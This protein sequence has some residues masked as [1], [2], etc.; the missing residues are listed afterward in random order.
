VQNNRDDLEFFNDFGG[1]AGD[2]REYVLLLNGDNR[3]PAPWINVIANPKFGFSI[4]ETGA[5][6]TW[7]YN[8]RE[9][10]ITPWSNDPVCDHASEAIYIRDN[11]TGNMMTPMSLGRVDR[12]GYRVRHGFGYSV[13]YHEEGGL[14]QELRVFTPKE[15]LIKIWELDLDNVSG[16]ELSLSLTYYVE[17]VLGIERNQTNPY[18]VTSF[19]NRQEYL[20]A[21]NVYNQVYRQYQGFIFSSDHVVGYSGDR[22]EVLG[23]GGSVQ[24]PFG[25]DGALSNT[26]GVGLDACGAIQITL[27]LRP[28]EHRHVVFG[29]GYSSD[30]DEIHALCSKY[31]DADRISQEFSAMEA[32]WEDILGKVQ[33]QTSDKAVNI[34]LNG[35]LLYQTVACRLFARAAFYQC[36][37]AYG[38]RDQLQDGMA[39]VYAQPDM[40]REQIL[41][42]SA[43]QY[44]EGDVQHWWHPPTGI[45]VRTRISDDLLWLPFVT[46]SYVSATSD[47]G[48]LDEARPYLISPVLGENQHDMMFVPEIS[49]TQDSLYNHCKKAIQYVRLGE[50]G[51][52]LMGGGDW[53]DGM[54]GVGIGGKGESVWLAWFFYAVLDQFIPLSQHM[55][56][57]SFSDTL[58]AIKTTLRGNIEK[59]AWDGEWYLRAFY[60]DGTKLG[61]REND[62]CRIDSI[63]QSWSIL[64]G[65]GQQDR[66]QK[67]LDSAWKHLVIEKESVS[68][69]LTPPFDKTAKNPGYIKN[70]YPGIRENGG[71]YTHGAVWLAIAAVLLGDSERAYSLFSILNPINFTANHND[72]LRYEKEPYVMTGDISYKAP[73]TGK[74]GWSW[75]T[76][77]AGWMYQGLLKYFM[78]L[79]IEGDSLFVSPCVPDAFGDYSIRYRYKS[80]TYFIEVKMAKDKA[81]TGEGSRIKLKDDGL[82][83]HIIIETV[84]ARQC[85]P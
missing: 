14:K 46:S 83:H 47:Y 16:R 25:L 38:F 49:A 19:D 78:G 32:H 48:I 61:S 11:M 82:E 50:R 81:A 42:A 1:F 31:K 35:W 26:S 56:D 85:K 70:Y 43:R 44:I 69:L 55:K 24:Y 36:G 65:A 71:Q 10:K 15:N 79:R 59:N 62:E 41:M 29:L 8:S 52:P 18:I 21:E 76:G 2:G 73:Y 68:L 51:L 13:F 57:V 4:S 39:L 54:N 34:M 12:G 80:S 17:W 22:Q 67:A 45:G 33:V 63:S 72:A 9:N 7:A 74:G 75:Y 30:D 37:G 64:S 58:Y 6:S 77:S 40:L 20:S 28:G 84:C 3:P 27:K 5:G 66:A 23:R 53:N 60:D